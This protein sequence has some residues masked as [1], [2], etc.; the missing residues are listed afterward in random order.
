MRS[1]VLFGA[2][3]QLGTALSSALAK[4]WQVHGFTRDQCNITDAASVTSIIDNLRPDAVI[5][6]AGYTNVEGAEQDEAGAMAINADAAGIL[7]AAARSVDAFYLSYSTDYVFNGAASTPYAETAAVQPLNV[8]GKSKAAGEAA[9]CKAGGRYLIIR[10]AWLYSSGFPNFLETVLRL[11]SE[12]EELGF[13]DDQ[14][15]S[16]TSARWLAGA[17]MKLLDLTL[18]ENAGQD[19]SCIVHAVCTGQA[20]WCRFANTIITEAR[21]RGAE[22]RA[23]EIRPIKTADYPALAQRPAYSV[24]STQYLQ[25]RWSIT[26]P[27]WQSAL[28]LEIDKRFGVKHD[29]S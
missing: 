17:S 26:P 1:V 18:D 2:G 23:K 14:I 7:A 4:Q 8:Y 11:A 13:V 20:S 28:K 19:M 25:Q 29:P 12:R 10:T 6:A 5:N 15:G 9:I 3:G 21:S 22:L 27:S 24:L 16:P